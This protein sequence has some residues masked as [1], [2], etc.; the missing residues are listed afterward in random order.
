[1]L[2][3][4]SRFHASVVGPQR[5]RGRAA[6]AGGGNAS[7]S[8]RALSMLRRWRSM[9]P[10]TRGTVD[11]SSCLPLAGCGVGRSPL[12]GVAVLRRAVRVLDRH[13]RRRRLRLRPNLVVRRR[14]QL[15]AA[16]DGRQ[17]HPR[18]RLVAGRDR[19]A[20]QRDQRLHALVAHLLLVQVELERQVRVAVHPDQQQVVQHPRELLAI[21]RQRVG[22]ERRLRLLE[23]A[24]EADHR[25][26]DPVRVRDLRQQPL[27]H[28]ER[29]GVVRGHPE[30]AQLHPLLQHHRL[31][32]RTLAAGSAGP[33]RRGSGPPATTPAP[34]EAGTPTPASASPTF[35][36]S[37]FACCN[38]ASSAT[39]FRNVSSGDSPNRW[40][41]GF[42]PRQCR[43]W[44]G[45]EVDERAVM[46]VVVP[47]RLRVEDGLA[48]RAPSGTPP[49]TGMT[50]AGPPP[51]SS[52]RTRCRA[53]ES[54]GTT[55]G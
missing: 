29:L 37:T 19:T 9:S 14:Q 38:A 51:G 28:I 52:A 26:R 47:V 30:V 44:S 42:S 15:V 23:I 40:S 39:T 41:C 1:M 10:C 13:H 48:A 24:L 27:A 53:R 55:T 45:R 8:G 21:R 6:R 18:P 33:P 22:V 50:T 46:G 7:I 12:A 54:R 36:S 25:A 11:T 43:I 16:R 32:R 3:A 35:A 49:A 5:L 17:V 20:R 4:S 2:S 31:V 34:P